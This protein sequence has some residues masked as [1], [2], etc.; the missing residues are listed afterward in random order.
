MSIDGQTDET[1]RAILTGTR[2]IAVVGA[3]DKPG[4]RRT[5]CSA[6]CC[7]VATTWRR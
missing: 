2:R 5:A 6:S 1:I 4:G 7:R 3:S